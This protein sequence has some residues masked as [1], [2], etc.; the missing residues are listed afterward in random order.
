[1]NPA[2]ELKLVEASYKIVF[3]SLRKISASSGKKNL[4]AE[5]T[6]KKGRGVRGE[7]E[8]NRLLIVHNHE[9]RTRRN[10]QPQKKLRASNGFSP[11]RFNRFFFKPAPIRK[12]CNGQILFLQGQNCCPAS[13]S[14][15][16]K[17]FKCHGSDKE[18][19]RTECSTLL[20][21]FFES[22]RSDK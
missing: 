17:V 9:Q 1:L 11:Y 5:S 10:Q 18:K 8:K 22:K 15:G 21:L 4:N 16:M 3:C 12:K 7:K 13:G 2:D 14:W 19:I 6:E 20:V